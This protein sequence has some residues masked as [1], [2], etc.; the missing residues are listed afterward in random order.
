MY[1]VLCTYALANR[2][3]DAICWHLFLLADN[4]VSFSW[5]LPSSRPFTLDPRFG[6]VPRLRIHFAD[7]HWPLSSQARP[8]CENG[9]FVCA[10]KATNDRLINTFKFLDFLLLF[11]FGLGGLREAPGGPEANG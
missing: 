2:L 6:G 10:Q 3:A 5:G 4:T 7:P 9:A 8:R 11:A 1:S